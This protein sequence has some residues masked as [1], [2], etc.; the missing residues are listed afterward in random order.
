MLFFKVTKQL[1]WTA[2]EER[3]LDSFSHSCISTFTASE[4]TKRQHAEKQI[5]HFLLCK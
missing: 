3:E 2:P 1:C 5:I 4:M